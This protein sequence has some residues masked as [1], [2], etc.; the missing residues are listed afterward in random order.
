MV[1]FN[2]VRSKHVWNDK[3][4]LQKQG[5]RFSGGTP[6]SLLANLSTANTKILAWGFF[7]WV[8]SA[9]AEGTG[10]VPAAGP[11]AQRSQRCATLRVE[12]SSHHLESVSLL[13]P[14]PLETSS[15]SAVLFEAFV[16]LLAFWKKTANIC[17]Y[18][19]LIHWVLRS[20]FCS[21]WWHYGL[22]IVEMH[23]LMQLHCRE[24]VKKQIFRKWIW[25]GFLQP[26]HMPIAPWGLYLEFL[27]A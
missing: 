12:P 13:V 10:A 4:A 8:P 15:I 7:R 2:T 3:K 14:S 22:L 20:Q 9:W 1:N 21:R 24:V 16:L 25:N 17:N 27:S 19:T 23:V 5:F 26:V 18:F 11:A 6:S